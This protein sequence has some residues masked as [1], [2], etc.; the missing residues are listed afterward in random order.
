MAFARTLRTKLGLRRKKP[1]PKFASVGRRTYGVN[2]G[3]I[4]GCAEHAELKIGAFCSIGNEVLFMCRA[5][6]P[7]SLV[8]TYP[9][10]VKMTKEV[11]T[12]ADLLLNGNLLADRQRRLDRAP[13]HHY[14]RH[15]NR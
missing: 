2:P 12:E 5:N 4:F 11:P 8:S 7:T 3:M 14:A 9:F 1:L 6:H 15:R 13:R 10:K